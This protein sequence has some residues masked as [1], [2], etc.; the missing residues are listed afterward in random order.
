MDRIERLIEQLHSPDKNERIEACD[1]LETARD[2]PQSALDALR[3]ASSD[4]EPK[5]ADAA[6]RAIATHTGVAQPFASREIPNNY[7]GLGFMVTLIFSILI[8]TYGTF[9]LAATRPDFDLTLPAILGPWCFSLFI[10]LYVGTRCCDAA[11]GLSDV[12]SWKFV[13]I[14]FLFAAVSGIAFG[15]ALVWLSSIP[16]GRWQWG[17]GDW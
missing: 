1:S 2:I 10:A 3:R 5:V 4:P 8:A 15:A 7:A 14:T 17:S 9:W 13:A 11:A 6:W 16:G 12:G